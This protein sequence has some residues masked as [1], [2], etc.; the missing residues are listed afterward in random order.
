MRKY[1]LFAY[2]EFYPRG[3][4]ADIHG[5]YDTVEEVVVEIAK[6]QLCC[7]NIV[8]RDTWEEIKF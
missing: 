4:I 3:G 1:V 8:D 7:Y 5:D 6:D 2:D